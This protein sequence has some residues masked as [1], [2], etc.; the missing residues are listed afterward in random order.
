MIYL[1]YWCIVFSLHGTQVPLR[2]GLCGS[3]HHCKFPIM[4]SVDTQEISEHHCKSHIMHRVDTQEIYILQ[5]SK[6]YLITSE[7]CQGF[8]TC[9]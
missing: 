5:V 8:E 9:S 2:Q 4:H 6:V 3:E 1:I 7:R